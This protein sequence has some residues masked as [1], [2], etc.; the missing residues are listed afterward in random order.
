MVGAANEN[1]N[2]CSAHCD[3]SIVTVTFTERNAPSGCIVHF[4]FQCSNRLCI[5]F[6]WLRIVRQHQEIT[7]DINHERRLAR[8]LSANFCDRAI[9]LAQGEGGA[10]REGSVHMPLGI[11]GTV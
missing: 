1:A 9:L 8:V 7:I 11:G 10:R 6:G 5:C 3:A 2:D 4:L